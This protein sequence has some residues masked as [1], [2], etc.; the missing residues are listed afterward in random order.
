MTMAFVLCE[1]Q[2]L[3]QLKLAQCPQ[4]WC[5][6]QEKSKIMANN[7]PETLKDTEPMYQSLSPCSLLTAFTV[8]YKCIGDAS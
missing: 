4:V 7:T 5:E 2:G 1:R 3:K 6:E 8:V